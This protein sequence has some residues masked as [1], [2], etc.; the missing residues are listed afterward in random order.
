MRNG[1]FLAPHDDESLSC[2][3][4]RASRGAFVDMLG[5]AIC[6]ACLRRIDADPRE[7][8]QMMFASRDLLYA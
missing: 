4:C 8:R 2:S 3:M 1:N 6:R 5:T 7:K